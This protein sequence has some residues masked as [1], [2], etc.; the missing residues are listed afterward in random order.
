MQDYPDRAKFI[1]EEERTHIREQLKLDQSS[2]ADEFAMKYVFDAL[3]DWKIWCHMFMAC[4]TFI[5]VY[6]FSLFLPTIIRD[7]GFANSTAQLMS[8]PP[9]IVACIIC[10][11][12]GWYADKLG[13]RGIF[14]IVFVTLPCV[15]NF[16]FFNDT[17]TDRT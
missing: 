10:V 5:G 14:M 6:S 2:L 12:G 16:P 9:Y 7:L 11:A 3:K 13:Q 1:T 17:C 8:T 4:T 15:S